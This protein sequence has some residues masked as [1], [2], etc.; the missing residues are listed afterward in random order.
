MHESKQ[1]S[2]W[3]PTDLLLSLYPMQPQCFFFLYLLQE[4]FAVIQYSKYLL[5]IVLPEVEQK[6]YAVAVK[7]KLPHT[8]KV[9]QICL[10]SVSSTTE[11][12]SCVCVYL[13][14]E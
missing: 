3:T 6:V 14:K 1:A 5:Q 10:L 7:L 8:V 2:D 11:N 4:D 13:E 12:F 9:Q